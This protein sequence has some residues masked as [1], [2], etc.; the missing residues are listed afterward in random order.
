MSQSQYQ[1][2]AQGQG[3]AAPYPQGQPGYMC[4]PVAQ[5]PEHVW[6]SLFKPPFRK[7]HPVVF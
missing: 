1:G 5:I 3:P 6:K 4:C 2:Y 7:R